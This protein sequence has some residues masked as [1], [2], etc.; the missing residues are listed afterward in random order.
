MSSTD[1][2]NRLL[3]TEDWKKIYQSF[4]SADF[5]SYDFENLRR[6]MVDY[7]RQNYPEDFN[8]YI[9]SS[10]YLAL[11]DVI[12]FLGQSVAFRVDLNA[13]EN[14]L[15][16]AERRD[17]ILRLSRLVS[18]NPKRNTAA[19]G[20]LKFTSIQTSQSVIDSN[21]R[22]LAGQTIIWND[23]TNDNWYDQFIKV[24][25]VAMPV[26]Q[27]FG[28]P[29]DKA[30]IYNI[31]TEKYT[32]QTLTS[33]IPL[34]SFSKVV[35][36]RTMNFE[37]TSTTFKGQEFIYEE[38][39][40]NGNKLSCI[41]RNDG[42]G[43][44][45]AGTGFF[46]N[47]TQGSF[48]QNQFTISQ[49]R[50]NEIIE[51]A[52]TGI[53]DT[54]V[55]L[56]KLDSNGVE[57]EEWT[58]VPNL[59]GNNIIYN[60]LN[61][62]I[63][64]IFSVITK[65]ND[66]INLSFSDGT[67]GN[68][69][70]GTFKVYYRTSNGLSY[71]INTRDIRNVSISIPYVSNTGQVESLSLSLSL[72][73]SVTTAD[74]AETST[75]IKA[76]A[77]AT[78]YTQNR[79]I[80]GEDYNISPLSASQQILKVKAVNRASSGISRY[81]DLV[82]PTG[83][84]SSTNLFADDGILYKE[85][86]Q[87]YNQFSY[88]TKTDIEGAIYN[89]VNSILTRPQL[90]NFFYAEYTNIGM[91]VGG[92]IIKWNAGTLTSG[93]L[94]DNT[95][96]PYQVGAQYTSTQLKFIKTGAM[97]KFTSPTGYYFDTTTPHNL[98]VAED[99]ANNLTV[100]TVKGASKNIWAAVVSVHLDGVSSNGIVLNVNVPTNAIVAQVMPQFRVTLESSVITTMIDLIFENKTFGLSYN[101]VT[102]LWQLV[103][104]SN[105]NLT[106]SFDLNTQN[107]VANKQADASWMVLFTT[108]NE[109]YTVT[110]RETRYIFES[111]KE[112][113]FYFDS[114]EK[115][116]NSISNTLVRD[117]VNILSINTKPSGSIMSFTTDLNWDIVSEY[118]GL[119]GYVDTKKII[120]SFADSDDNG[121]VD[122]P[123]LF[124]NIV[125]PSVSDISSYIVQE[126]Y[127][128]AQGQ[129]D[130]RY[131]ENTDLVSIE[132]DESTKIGNPG[133]YYYFPNSQTVKK[134]NESGILV[135]SLDYKLFLGRDKLK[136]QYIHN[137]NYDS[138]IDPSASNI[139]DVYLLTKSYDTAIRQ[140][141]NGVIT[142]KPMPPGTEE[143]YNLAAPH[144]NLIKSISDEVIYHPVTYK[145]LF[146]ETADPEVQAIFKITKTPGR[147]VSDNDIKSQVITAINKFF[148]LDNWDFGDTFYF[149]ELATYVMNEVSPNI[150]NFVIVPRHDSLNFGGLFEIRSLNNQILIN[151]ATVDDIE[152]ISGLTASNIKSSNV[153]AGNNTVNRQTLSSSSYGSN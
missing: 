94:I 25:N 77:P 82:D 114:S 83:K 87:T 131:V 34:Y 95:S 126:R 125:K 85:N 33:N 2:Q 137:A 48:G 59:E 151:G 32:L 88:V 24:L 7:I 47:F 30:T 72:A 143:L 26:T 46:L 62:S 148:L 28:N 118:I 145:I 50:S 91:I 73:T 64:N 121:V 141:V 120:L 54:D 107:N 58:Q 142:E 113:R 96:I 104:E 150:S 102:Q 70:T 14:F 108:N 130:Y 71:D 17:S 66:S 1:R 31:P 67:F 81:F 27:Q 93:N 86:Y 10:E 101:A 40:K 39:P 55:W 8:D 65:A 92:S 116:R 80:T 75:S 18:Y 60:S 61:K 37:V 123:E 56:Y 144:L 115:I 139:I 45:S 9:E 84:F 16:L 140:W 6:T 79:M 100:D 124:Y 44:G 43:Y 38:P 42:R 134:A 111:D 13:R 3:V 110:S 15:E 133:S 51:V 122:N 76:N 68:I 90:R 127:L 57:V 22:N 152:I 97:I 19:K 52:T 63:R 23:S 12:A 36:G 53:N 99:P 4:K 153:V 132:L 146:G 74:S 98:L 109:N 106:S 147:V 49:P 69:P 5:Q 20:L 89:T 128:I 135:P 105:L 78:F 112:L 119:D 41:F 11:I 138:R 21:G 129:E 136:F 35:A 149:T 29:S 103:Y 117:K